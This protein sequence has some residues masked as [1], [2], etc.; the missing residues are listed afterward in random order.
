MLRLKR[1][2]RAGSGATYVLM[3]DLKQELARGAPGA[4]CI[5]HGLA[6]LGF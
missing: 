2:S 5:L 1:S 6:P 3:F 4:D